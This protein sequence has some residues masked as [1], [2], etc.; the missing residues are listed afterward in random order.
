MGRHQKR[1]Q[2][3]NGAVVAVEWLNIWLTGNQ[4]GPK[5]TEHREE[6]GSS[7]EWRI[8]RGTRCRCCRRSRKYTTSQFNMSS[9]DRISII[10]F[11]QCIATRVIKSRPPKLCCSRDARCRDGVGGVASMLSRRS[12]GARAGLEKALGEIRGLVS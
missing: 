5:L 9:L 4:I 2:T 12:R 11:V 3:F 6:D 1:V 10:A 8:Q 7:P